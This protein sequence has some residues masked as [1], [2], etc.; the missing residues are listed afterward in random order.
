VIALTAVLMMEWDNPKEE[1]R[2]KEYREYTRESLSSW[3][4]RVKEGIVKSYGSWT[5]GSGHMIFWV[6]FENVERFSKLW[7][8]KE[9]QMSTTRFHPL[10]DNVRIRLLRPGIVV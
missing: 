4:R 8:D 2:L 3:D 7:S 1:A 10:A 9:Y 6:E 5:D